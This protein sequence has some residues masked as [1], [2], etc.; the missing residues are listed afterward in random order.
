MNEQDAQPRILIALWKANL[1][2]P[3]FQHS[4]P[5]VIIVDNATS[6]FLMLKYLTVNLLWPYLK[7]ILHSLLV[8]TFTLDFLFMLS[9]KRQEAETSEV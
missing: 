8:F 3:K 2:E 1:E 4:D 5:S 7:M 6:N 9:L